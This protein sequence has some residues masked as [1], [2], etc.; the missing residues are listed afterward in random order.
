MTY[1]PQFPPAFRLFQVVTAVF[2]WTLLCSAAATAA[3]DDWILEAKRTIS[4][5]EEALAD[6]RRETSDPE[7]LNVW[8]RQLSDVRLQGQKC[9]DART[10]NIQRL[11][12][13]LEAVS[14][15]DSAA[16][17]DTSESSKEVRRRITEQETQLGRCSTLLVDAISIVDKIRALQA[18][19]LKSHI[20]NRGPNILDVSIANLQQADSLYPLFK[21]FLLERLQLK[22]MENI[23][24]L[25]LGILLTAA[26]LLGVWGRRQIL[27]RLPKTREGAFTTA[28]ICSLQ[29]C[30]A[31]NLPLL[32]VLITA[33]A[34]FL[35]MLPTAPV[36]P[37]VV[38]LLGL[39]VYLAGSVVV[40]TF[41]NPCA[42]AEHY[43]DADPAYCKALGKRLHV[44]LALVL[45]AV[46]V[47]GMGIHSILSTEQ[48]LITR[49][50]FLTVAIVILLWLVITMRNA[51]APFNSRKLRSLIVL[52][53]LASLLAEM[54]GLRNLSVYLLRG[55]IGTAMLGSVLWVV[56]VLLLELFDGLDEGHYQWEKTLRNTLGLA[57]DEPVPGLIW[58]RLLAALSIWLL[59]AAGAFVLWGYTESVWSMLRDSVTTG[60][61]VAGMQ[62]VPV[63]L[64]V[65]VAVFAVLVAAVRWMRN[66]A[67]P[68]WVAKSKISHG[69]KEAIITISGYVGL[70]IAALIG[71][72]LAGFSFTNLAIVVGALSVGIG[73]GLQNIVNN[74]ISGIIL[75][76]ERPIRTGDWIVVGGTE[77]YV[78]KISIRSTQIETFDRADVI[79]PNSELISNQVTNWM[80]NDPWGRVTVPIGVAYGTDVEKLRELLLR[81]ATDHPLVIKDSA[82][83]SPPKVLFR[84][85]GDS[86]LNFELRCFIRLVD[87]RLD[88]QSELNFAIERTL[89]EAGIQIPFPQHDLHIRSV[90]PSIGLTR[91][92]PE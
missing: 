71:L 76:F 43:L 28:M 38:V 74:F 30:I 9:I 13:T 53:L 20:L 5:A 18:A 34:W 24:W 2:L 8:V 15:T 87:R 55:L 80:L 72:S 26:A 48:W 3:E 40:R 78:R 70:I 86:A 83:V 51:P 36:P 79:V 31:A 44:L 7:D 16:T 27:Q 59:F 85:F 84:S 29:S 91:P 35:I 22:R 41:L 23:Q 77:G 46:L 1:T 11:K 66:E 60:F 19:T 4:R 21:S 89:R 39:L 50:A 65:A 52:A 88:T 58:L 90:D 54:W 64:I 92:P 68:G 56:N 32:L 69:A 14:G 37:S 12:N 10:D 63:N 57:Q 73:F 62:V 61:Q 82:R 45:I 33:G 75:L 67:L 42:P 47:Y 81:V 25:V 49:A 6:F 17:A